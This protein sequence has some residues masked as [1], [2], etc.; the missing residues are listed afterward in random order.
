MHA[1]RAQ[2]LHYAR[3]ALAPHQIV[4]R[5][6]LASLDVADLWMDVDAFDQAIDRGDLQ[7]AI[8]LYTGDLLLEDRFEPSTEPRPEQLRVRPRR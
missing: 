3:Q 5:G 1:E 7:R 2:A 6:A 4:V 8:A